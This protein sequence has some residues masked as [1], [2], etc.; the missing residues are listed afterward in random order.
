MQ[1]FSVS[2]GKSDFCPVTRTLNGQVYPGLRTVVRIGDARSRIT[3]WDANWADLHRAP[4]GWLA[5]I[6]F[7][8]QLLVATVSY[9]GKDK[10]TGTLFALFFGSLLIWSPI[11]TM[12]SLWGS[13]LGPGPFLLVGFAIGG[14][15]L[16]LAYLLG[17]N[18]LWS[19]LTQPN[20]AR[21]AN[22]RFAPTGVGAA[23]AFVGGCFWGAFAIE[24]V[25][26]RWLFGPLPIAP[27]LCQAVLA[28]TGPVLVLLFFLGNAVAIAW[29]RKGQKWRRF[30][31]LV[32]LAG[33]LALS[34]ALV[35]GVAAA[36]LWVNL[37]AAD[38]LTTFGL[39][40]LRALKA[41]DAAYVRALPFE[42]VRAEMLTTWATVVGVGAL[43]VALVV[44]IV[45]TFFMPDGVKRFSGR[46][47]RGLLGCIVIP[48]ILISFV[49]ASL[50]IG[51]DIIQT[52]TSW[53][54]WGLER[55]AGWREGLVGWLP[56]FGEKALGASDGAAGLMEVYGQSALRLLP[57]AG[58]LLLKPVQ[59]GLDH[60]A[61]VLRYLDNPEPERGRLDA[62]IANLRA[63]EPGAVI[64]VVGH[65][66]GSRIAVDTVS[67]SLG[68]ERLATTGSP[69]AALYGGFLEE[70]N[71]PEPADM[72]PW[73][74]FW[75]GS[76]FVGGS[77]A[78]LGKKDREIR[79]N[80][81]LNHLNYWI[82]PKVMNFL[83]NSNPQPERAS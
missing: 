42:V 73:M 18:A 17:G 38:K 54:L 44:W 6:P 35:T 31:A 27:Q 49:A 12:L 1:A 76:D 45:M 79:A 71:L 40:D 60:S 53:Q 33:L 11:P 52:S 30:R 37:F 39:V 21:T 67:K 83:L 10:H 78:K 59:I 82:E 2:I 5:R 63:E 32:S 69:V 34:F 8:A 81:R 19:R 43:L 66:Q 24:A 47:F 4:E 70:E 77:I 15:C 20:I 36:I 62:L 9:A 56:W 28:L 68:V 51:S 16:W 13:L 3:F 65:S 74:N 61:D 23:A 29:D 75:R 48:A 55:V 41:W 22:V 7:V 26:A 80:L 50:L 72:P 14:G 25:I 58:G 57:V 64:A 46:V